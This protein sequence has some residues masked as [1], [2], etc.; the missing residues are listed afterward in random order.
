VPTIVDHGEP[1]INRW[2]LRLYGGQDITHESSTQDSCNVDALG[3][4]LAAHNVEINILAL[5]QGLVVAVERLDARVMDKNVLALFGTVLNRN[6]SKT[7]LV[8]KPL[9]L[10]N[11]ISDDDVALN[12]RRGRGN[13]QG[14]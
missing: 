8:I 3:S 9:A 5:L 14:G 13:S 12:N 10:S 4:V 6:K 11:D 2:R 1:R 7:K